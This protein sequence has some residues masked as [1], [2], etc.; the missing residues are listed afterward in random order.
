M[1]FYPETSFSEWSLAS[2]KFKAL[3][4]NVLI[5]TRAAIYRPEQIE[6][7]DNVRVDDFCILSGP[8]KIGRN[9]HVA[10]SSS[11][12]GCQCGIT[13]EDFCGLGPGCHIFAGGSDYS[14]KSMTN[15]TVP[16]EFRADEAA[17]V[18]LARHVL[19]GAMTTVFP[20]V[21]M[22]EGTATGAYSMVNKNTLAWSI[23]AGIPAK[24]IEE[25]SRDGLA[26]ERQYIEKYG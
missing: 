21:V 3:G 16:V 7:G 12:E 15:P 4:K 17:P 19:L 18:Y 10:H 9:V 8:I 26:L 22:A 14:G 1:G 5:S 25:R 20:G 6:I 13:L 11:L 23:Y 24:F 2:F